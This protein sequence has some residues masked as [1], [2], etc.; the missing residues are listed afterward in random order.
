MRRALRA[1]SAD[2][3]ACAYEAAL[4][5]EARRSLG[6]YYTPSPIVEAVLEFALDALLDRAAHAPDP[7]VQL[8]SIRVVD[9]ACGS[10]RFLVAA[11]RRIAGRMVEASGGR[12]APVEALRQAATTCVAGVDIDPVAVE[13]ARAALGELGAD[14]RQAIVRADALLDDDAVA[15]WLGRCHAVVGNPPFIDSERSVARGAHRRDR[16]RA[17]FTTARGNFDL[18]TLFVELGMRMVGEGGRVALI[19]PA[20]L[21][22]SDAGRSIQALALA[23]RPV[24]WLRIAGGFDAGVE[25]GA[26]VI[27]RSGTPAGD[28][29]RVPCIAI[30]ERGAS[31]RAGEA[32]LGTLRRMPAGYLCGAWRAGA[33]PLDSLLARGM[34]LAD[35]ADASDA[36]TTEEAYRLAPLLR[37][38]APRAGDVRVVN[39]GLIDPGRTLWG[40]RPMRYLGRTLTRPVVPMEV[41]RRSLPRQAEQACGTQVA[42]AGLASRLEAVVLPEGWLA[43]KSVVVLRPR[44]GVCPRA[45]AAWLNAPEASELYALLFG[46]RGFGSGSLAIGP[47]QLERLPITPGVADLLMTRAAHPRPR[48]SRAEVGDRRAAPRA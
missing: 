15:P 41:L 39:T 34:T 21:M 46:G 6:A 13:L 2:D 36:A 27:E 5:N 31:S 12:L 28:G 9:P 7:V 44:A 35:V 23:Q 25:T 10:G 18:S 8:R 37:D 3:V 30:D 19:T 29:E 24:A 17:E 42:V 33:P 47:R 40:E 32:T 20:K 1:H 14:A 26:L 11:A 45:L 38:R 16:L 43:G 4:P 48:H 22:A